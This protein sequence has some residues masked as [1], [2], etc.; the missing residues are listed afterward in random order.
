[1]GN[2]QYINEGLSKVADLEIL[3][4]DFSHNNKKL[5]VISL[6]ERRIVKHLTVKVGCTRTPVLL[7]YLAKHPHLLR[8]SNSTLGCLQSS[9]SAY[10][11]LG[12]CQ[13]PL[14]RGRKKLCVI[15]SPCT[16]TI[17]QLQLCQVN[18]EMT[19]NIC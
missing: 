1:M 18:K 15:V 12:V 8:C 14:V 2:K 10:K 7:C 19:R 6:I 16:C 4:E 9:M 5:M 13:N 3:R 11:T 17:L